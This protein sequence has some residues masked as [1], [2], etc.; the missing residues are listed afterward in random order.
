ML[1]CSV[2]RD[3]RSVDQG[4]AHA[5]G[6]IDVVTENDRFIRKRFVA[7]GSQRFGNRFVA[8]NEVCQKSRWFIPNPILDLIAVFID[9]AFIRAPAGWGLYTRSKCVRPAG[10]QKTVVDCPGA[11]SRCK[12]ARRS[13]RCWMLLGLSLPG[14]AVESDL[15]RDESTPESP[16]RPSPERPRC[17]DDARR[18]DGRVRRRS[19]L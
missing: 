5:L 12:S 7:S 13:S 11:G 4:L 1:C 8:Q 16:A 2:P 10:R 6:V 14:V 15:W 9:H 18:D 17:R 19:R 3:R